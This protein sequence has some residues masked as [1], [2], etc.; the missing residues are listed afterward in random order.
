MVKDIVQTLGYL[1]IPDGSIPHEIIDGLALLSDNNMGADPF[2]Q[3]PIVTRSSESFFIK[4]KDEASETIERQFKR[5]TIIVVRYIEQQRIS[6][7]LV[8]HYQII[9]QN[10]DLK[11]LCKVYRRPA[12]E[13]DEPIYGIFTTSEQGKIISIETIKIEVDCFGDIKPGEYMYFEII[14][15]T[16]FK[17][18]YIVE[19]P[20][21]GWIAFGPEKCS[22]KYLELVR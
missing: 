20:L 5:V 7:E 11:I 2:S 18:R 14:T 10:A 16:Q 19:P 12:A 17:Q 4:N 21:E 8:L 9:T 3:K 1:K 13:K 22:P 15:E 6:G